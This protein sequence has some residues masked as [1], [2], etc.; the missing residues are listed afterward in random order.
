V[1]DNL[2]VII[3]QRRFPTFDFVCRTNLSRQ[4]AIARLEAAFREP[5]RM[6]WPSP[7]PQLT[8]EVRD[9]TFSARPRAFVRKIFKRVYSEAVAPV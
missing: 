4:E 7:K 1:E 3:V 9:G 6:S 8:G 2:I 5:S